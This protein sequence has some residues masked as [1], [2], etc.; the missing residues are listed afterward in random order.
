MKHGPNVKDATEL[1]RFEAVPGLLHL[2]VE[3]CPEC[4]KKK[5][6]K[7][8]NIMPALRKFHIVLESGEERDVTG[9]EARV[10]DGAF[11]H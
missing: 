3:R 10:R 2:Y 5:I 4:I 7:G 11:N 8:E 1:T 9:K 6:Y